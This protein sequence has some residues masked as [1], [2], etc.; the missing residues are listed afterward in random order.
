[1]IEVLYA[2]SLKV[3]SS[4]PDEVIEFFDVS[5]PSSCTMVHEVY[6]ATNR[7]EYQKIFLRLKHSRRVRLTA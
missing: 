1:M 7:N 3:A 6:L 5:N 2:S 4:S